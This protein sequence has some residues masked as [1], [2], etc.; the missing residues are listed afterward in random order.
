M[1]SSEQAEAIAEKYLEK[2]GYKD[3]EL[4]KIEDKIV[5]WLVSFSSANNKCHIQVSK[6][7]GSVLGFT[8]E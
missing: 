6:S 4:E 1:V 7:N 3:Y 8:I 2:N 5:K